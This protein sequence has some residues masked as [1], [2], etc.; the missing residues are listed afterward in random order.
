MRKKVLSIL[1]ASL[2]LLSFATPALA[3]INPYGGQEVFDV[4]IYDHGNETVYPEVHD[5]GP[6]VGPPG[7]GDED[8][9]DKIV[10]GPNPAAVNPGSKDNV[11]VYV[12]DVPVYSDVP[13]YVD[14]NSR[15]MVP[16]RFI[17]EALGAKV[18]WDQANQTAIIDLEDKHITLKIGEKQAKINNETVPL[19]TN[20]VLKSSRTFVP[21]RFISEALGY[22]VNWDQNLYRVYIYSQKEVK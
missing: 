5:L 9:P 21:L 17:S 12:D 6:S 7:M 19:D 1:T 8:F 16:I 15:T 22:K 10:E 13:A 3:D 2:L 14:A 4:D 11:Q 20:A 18:E